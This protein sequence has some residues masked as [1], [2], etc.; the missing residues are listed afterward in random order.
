MGA[1][2]LGRSL[3]GSCWQMVGWTTPRTWPRPRSLPGGSHR[4]PI[5]RAL[6]VLATLT[7]GVRRGDM[8][9]A[10]TTA[11]EMQ[12]EIPT[13]LRV[14]RRDLH[15]VQ[16]AGAASTRRPRPRAR[17]PRTRVR[18]DR[19]APAA[20]R[21]GTGRG[22][23]LFVSLSH[24]ATSGT[25]AAVV[26]GAMTNLANDNRT[27]PSITASA[28]HALGLFVNDAEELERVAVE[29]VHPWTRASAGEDAGVVR[30]GDGDYTQRLAVAPN[31]PRDLREYRCSARRQAR[32]R[33]TATCLAASRPRS[34][35]VPDVR[36]GQPHQHG[37][38]RVVD[39]V[40]EG[41]TNRQVAAQ[42]CLS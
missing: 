39:L 35:G 27:F 38:H 36:L 5:L 21:R 28:R 9:V 32:P 4:R 8:R 23:L 12:A 20:P 22:T 3:C 41:L 42:M 10:A 33:A 18:G 29:H 13:E 2:L 31:G 34:T 15:L 25:P 24:R 16:R 37:R 1:R 14:R 11:A 26:V 40:A 6:R 17:S 30:A 19:R 7:T